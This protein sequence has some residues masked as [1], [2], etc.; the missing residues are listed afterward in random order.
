MV[1]YLA[2]DTGDADF[3]AAWFHHVRF[4][5]HHWQFWCMVLS[6]NNDVKAFP[7]PDK[8]IIEMICDWIGAVKA[9]KSTTTIKEWY[10]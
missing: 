2:Y 6:E 7:M 5:D 1:Q 3:D 10:E 9:Q 8:A 4:N